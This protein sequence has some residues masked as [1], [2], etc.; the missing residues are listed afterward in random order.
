MSFWESKKI[1]KTRKQHRCEYCGADIPIGSSC[2]N[3]VGTY[4]GDFNNYYLCERCVVFLDLFKDNSESEL[5]SFVNDLFESNILSC[6]ECGEHNFREYDFKDNMQA[7][8][9]ECDDCE[10]KWTV[11]LSLERFLGYKEVRQDEFD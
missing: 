7:I 9:I 3:E 8:E 5:G 10:A 11:D 2:R 1:K 4:E 6:P